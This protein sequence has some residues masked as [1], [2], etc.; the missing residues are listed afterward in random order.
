LKKIVRPKVVICWTIVAIGVLTVALLLTGCGGQNENAGW[1]NLF[2]DVGPAWSPD[3]SK[4]AF[5]SPNKW[6]GFDIW[7]V[8]AD[9]SNKVKFNNDAAY[10]NAFSPAWSPDGSR[11][12]F[13]SVGAEEKFD[14]WVMDADGSNQINLTGN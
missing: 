11:I 8:N 2:S 10:Y 4:I 13:V 12:A 1:K 5:S 9:G 3:G 6:E 14:I 7:V